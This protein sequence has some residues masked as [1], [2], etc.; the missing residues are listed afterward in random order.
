[1]IHPQP[2]SCALIT[3]ASSGIG[4]ALAVT[5][6]KQRVDRLLLCGRNQ[7]ALQSCLKEISPQVEV[8]FFCF[9]LATEIGQNKLVEIIEAYA[10]DIIVNNAGL[11]FYGAASDLSAQ[12]NRDIIEVNCSALVLSTT[13]ACRVLRGQKREGV[14]CNVSSALAQFP[15]PLMSVYAASKAFVNFF[16]QAIDAEVKPYGIRVL[17]ACPG[18]VETSFRLR[19]A[20]GRSASSS[21][22]F[23]AMSA[24]LVAEKIWKQIQTK[25]TVQII[26]WK[27]WL[28]VFCARLLPRCVH[29]R[30]LKQE[31]ER[32]I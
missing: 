7:E 31:I 6:A 20:K 19:A 22:S 25:K 23:F 9:D 3:G 1:M 30:I 14:V 10:P 8:L 12:E 21:G 17:T 13:T 16:S 32:R 4:K 11:G 2:N 26:D 15:T 28:L 24:E 5:F 18:Q 29:F 27:T